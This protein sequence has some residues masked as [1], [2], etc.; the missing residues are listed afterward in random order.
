MNVCYIYNILRT[1]YTHTFMIYYFGGGT[2]K[3]IFI[4]LITNCTTEDGV[5]PLHLL[6]LHF[7]IKQEVTLSIALL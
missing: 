6:Y 3:S 1:K 7:T 5:L 4:K 2:S